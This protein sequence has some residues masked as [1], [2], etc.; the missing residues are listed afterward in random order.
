MRFIA[1]CVL[2]TAIVAA[3]ISVTEPW[4][5]ATA[6]SAANG[7][8]F[9]EIANAGADADALT[10]AS[11]AP[12]IADHVEIHAHTKGEDGVMR[13]APVA[14]VAIPAKSEIALKPGGYHLMLLGLK[15]P[16]VEGQKIPVTLTFTKAGSITVSAVIGSIAA[17]ESPECADGSCCTPEKK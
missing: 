10:A 1:L 5:R 4:A 7:A 15:Q 8:I 17:T 6:P 11:V 3:D 2:S 9:A 16:L 12:T 13:M 14:T